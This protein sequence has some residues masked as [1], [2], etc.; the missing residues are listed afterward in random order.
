[1]GFQP[2]T[3]NAIA[4]TYG[5][6]SPA[7]HKHKLP[8]EWYEEADIMRAYLEKAA[9][10]MKKWVDTRRRHVEYKEGDQV[11][12]KVLPQQF[13]LCEK[14]TRVSETLRGTLSNC[15]TYGQR[16]VSTPTSAKIQDS[17]GLSRE[18]SQALSWR[19]KRPKSRRIEAC[20][21]CR[22]HRI[23]QR[24]GL[25]PCGSRGFKKR[26]AST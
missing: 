9:R 14:C 21:N 22:C 5:G 16:L 26:C 17:S 19:Y 3:P 23:R 13:K 6:K 18:P 4:S 20:A 12:I 8:R 7:A 1:M 25:H 15:T 11:M 2:M 24:C 10:K